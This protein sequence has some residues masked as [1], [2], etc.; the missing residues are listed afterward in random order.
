MCF[1]GGFRSILLFLRALTSCICLKLLFSF[2]CI[3]QYLDREFEKK[4]P[5][6][7]VMMNRDDLRRVAGWDSLCDPAVAS[8]CNVD[9]CTDFE[10][11]FVACSVPEIPI[12]S[13]HGFRHIMWKTDNM[14]PSLQYPHD[15]LL[16]IV[17]NPSTA[18][19]YKSL[20][21]TF[22]RVCRITGDQ[23][24]SELETAIESL[25]VY[26]EDTIQEWRESGKYQMDVSS[27]VAAPE[28]ASVAAG[29]KVLPDL[30]TIPCLHPSWLISQL[31]VITE[32]VHIF[33]SKITSVRAK[34]PTERVDYCTR[35]SCSVPN[36]IFD[37]TTTPTLKNM[38]FQSSFGLDVYLHPI[39]SSVLDCLFGIDQ[40]LYASASSLFCGVDSRRFLCGRVVDVE[41]VKVTKVTRESY[42]S[43]LKH[44]PLGSWATFV[45]IDMIDVL[46][47][48]LR[49]QLSV[50]YTCV[51]SAEDKEARIR[52]LPLSN[53]S[54]LDKYCKNLKYRANRVRK[55]K[56]E[57]DQEETDF[58]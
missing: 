27:V 6:C 36:G 19:V 1:G 20:E 22:S 46:F 11:D 24:I 14:K 13:S 16:P 17:V 31:S 23:I 57:M 44:M 39:C 8:D 54:L 32:A 33:E 15:A 42:R 26:R 5:V 30:E 52:S 4:C 25:Q 34:L 18:P 21:S 10:H 58:R 7:S 55:S 29:K 43:I 50:E 48:I 45:Y 47:E 38:S 40:S 12:G 35:V 49:S 37:V 56:S 9:V 3:L 41:R 2:L 28:Y 53:V 51:L